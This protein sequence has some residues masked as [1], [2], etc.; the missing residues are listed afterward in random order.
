MTPSIIRQIFVL[1]PAVKKAYDANVPGNV[2]EEKFWTEFLQSLYFHRKSVTKTT[3]QDLFEK[4]EAEEEKKADLALENVRVDKFVDLTSDLEL[5]EGYGIRPDELTAP[6]RLTGYNSL[7]KRFNRQS[8]RVLTALIDEAEESQK[9][10]DETDIICELH[11]DLISPTPRRDFI[12]LNIQDKQ[13]YF[14]GHSEETFQKIKFTPTEYPSSELIQAF[15]KEALAFE[16]NL[17]DAIIPSDIAI[18]ISSEISQQSKLSEGPLETT[19]RVI[20]DDFKRKVGKLFQ[21]MNE[22]LRHFWSTMPLKLPHAQK[23][24]NI[25]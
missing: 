14:E 21:G 16:P 17:S 12:P 6:S 25:N 23:K 9:K 24:V 3:D 22:R 13:R 10:T 18:K 19:E 11:P 8:S 15:K 2:S 1:Y 4:F 20:P 7:L 5:G